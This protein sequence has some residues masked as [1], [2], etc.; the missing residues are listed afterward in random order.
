MRALDDADRLVTTSGGCRDVDQLRP[1]ILAWCEVHRPEVAEAGIA[2]L[3]HPSDGYSNETIIVRCHPS[4]DG[5]PGPCIV[6]RLPPLTASFPDHD[7]GLQALVQAAA[8]AAGIPTAEPITLEEDPRWLGVPFIVMPFI[9]GTIPGEASLFDPW[10]TDATP[11]QQRDAQREMVGVLAAIHGV[12]WR[13]AG[14]DQLF[15]ADDALTGQLDHW[16]RFFRWAADGDSLPRI[17]AVLVWCRAHKPVDEVA[18]SLVWGDARLGNLVVDEQRRTR[19]VL[20]WELATIGPIEMD[21]GWFT[22]MELILVALTGMDPL[23]GFAPVEDVERDLSE[24]I[25]RPLQDPAWHRIFAVFR[26]ICIN[27]RQA[28]IAAEAGVKYPLPRGEA[29]PLLPVVE[30][31]IDDHDASAGRDDR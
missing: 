10:L 1:Q 20:D 19:A 23:D 30:R 7:F 31:W 11:T 28:D 24:A 15:R 26:S 21:L 3:V 17:E 29:N 16:D 2:E 18:P 27:L 9:H 25:G 4:A 13:E 8:S 22:G 14:L 6:V 5:S 12:D